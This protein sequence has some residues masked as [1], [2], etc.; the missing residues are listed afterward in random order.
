[1]CVAKGH[2]ALA[3]AYKCA[4]EFFRGRV[5]AAGGAWLLGARPN[6]CAP[7][8]STCVA[9]VTL[10]YE[11]VP[12]ADETQPTVGGGEPVDSAMAETQ[13]W[14]MDR[15]NEA[16]SEYAPDRDTHNRRAESGHYVHRPNFPAFVDVT[17]GEEECL[18][19]GCSSRAQGGS[20]QRPGKKTKGFVKM[21]LIGEANAVGRLCCSIT[22]GVLEMAEDIYAD[23]DGEIDFA[24]QALEPPAEPHA[25]GHRRFVPRVPLHRRHRPRGVRTHATAGLRAGEGHGD[26]AL[27]RRDGGLRAQAG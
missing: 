11:Y 13:Q 14:E 16:K 3:K 25:A 12:L 2:N 24:Q 17:S 22:D 27:G 6:L 23:G 26:G 15:A 18:W 1:M 4:H 5:R 8:L 10:F 21:C 9:Q 7:A 19:D 20:L